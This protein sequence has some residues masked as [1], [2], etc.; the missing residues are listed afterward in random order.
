VIEEQ[1]QQL[2]LRARELQA[3]RPAVGLP[4][5]AVQRQVGEAQLRVLALARRLGAPQQRAQP[6]LELLQCERLDEVVVGA[7][8]QA[9]HAVVDGV[10]RGQH[11]HGRA[12]AGLAQALADLQAVDSR[13]G[14]VEND[15]VEPR[16]G[17]PVERLAAV[18]GE[19]DFVSVQP[20]R[21]IERGAHGRLIIDDQHACHAFN[22]YRAGT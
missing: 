19:L 16:L 3:P 9:G 14:N 4:R 17:Q 12:V 7:G 21:A 20:Q 18:G 6:R 8:V 15:R 22:R 11:Q 10:A 5:A 2:E 13:H 1:G